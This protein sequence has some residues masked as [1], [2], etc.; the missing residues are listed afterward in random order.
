MKKSRGWD[1]GKGDVLEV[2]TPAA[3]TDPASIKPRVSVEE[4]RGRNEIMA[5][6][7]GADSLNVYFR[8]KGTGP[9][10]LL[11]AKRVRFPLDDE[12]PPATAGQ[13]EER[14]YQVIAV[15]GDDEVG[16]PSD[17]VTAVFRP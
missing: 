15:I 5:K 17:I 16:Q 4:K 1:D 8:P 9:M 12:T 2:N 14:E 3:S 11:A 13:P 7:L 6:K 10:R